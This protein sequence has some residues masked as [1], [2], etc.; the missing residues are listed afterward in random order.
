M[1][2]PSPQSEKAENRGCVCVCPRA[3]CIYCSGSGK[4]VCA[5]KGKA[6]GFMCVFL[7]FPPLANAYF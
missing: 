2:S 5:V 3:L 4:C 1:S 7:S 6:G